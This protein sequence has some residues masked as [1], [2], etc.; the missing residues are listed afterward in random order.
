MILQ[1]R[2]DDDP[3]LR[4]VSREV[5]PHEFETPQFQNWVT[6]MISTCSLLQAAGLASNQVGNPIRVVVLPEG[7]V[8]VNPKILD[9]STEVETRPE[10][11]FSVPDKTWW[12]RR[13]WAV[14]VRY[15]DR[16]GVESEEV[17]HDFPARVL[18]HELDHL[19]G[20]LM[21]DYINEAPVE[22]E[23]WG[24]PLGHREYAPNESISASIA[25][26]IDEAKKKGPD[27][28]VADRERRIQRGIEHIQF[29]SQHKRC[30]RLKLRS[31]AEVL[32]HTLGCECTVK[33]V[34]IDTASL[35]RLI[36]HPDYA[37]LAQA[38]LKWQNKTME[39]QAQPWLEFKPTRSAIKKSKA[40]LYKFLTRQ[41]KWD[42]RATKTFTEVGSDGYIYRIGL[43]RAA[44]VRTERDGQTYHIC[45]VL[46]QNDIPV[47]DEVLA[48]L[49]LI[50]TDVR[51][52]LKRSNVFSYNF[53]CAGSMQ[54]NYLVQSWHNG[55]WNL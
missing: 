26:A 28:A 3:I 51:Q 47:Y 39:A 42:L 13:P 21:T 10:G 18:Q 6:A 17:L 49:L 1:V 15:Q 4:V 24:L 33:S 5:E 54:R 48:Q 45:S 52:F 53:D 41:Q 12:V 9:L 20:V 16:L 44:N 55:S 31:H 23:Y 29:W 50:R 32:T 37:L 2:T 40:L 27:E 25:A 11:C 14:R 35:V 30:G 8:Y 22:K 34:S 38:Y 43:N 7:K 19:N 36:R 46:V